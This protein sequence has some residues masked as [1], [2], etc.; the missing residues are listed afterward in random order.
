MIEAESI[1][2]PAPDVELP[3]LTQFA[4]DDGAAAVATRIAN[5]IVDL[6]TESPL[7]ILVCLP[8]ADRMPPWKVRNLCTG[9][10]RLSC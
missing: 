10:E 7:Q 1:K 5:N 6:R 8:L 2:T 4:A 9:T 3:C